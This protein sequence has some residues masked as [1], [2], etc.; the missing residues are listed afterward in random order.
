MHRGV[1]VAAEVVV[2]PDV[3]DGIGRGVRGEDEG[4]EAFAGHAGEGFCGFHCLT[5]GRK[6]EEVS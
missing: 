6:L 4:G 1:D 5:G 2:V 3:D